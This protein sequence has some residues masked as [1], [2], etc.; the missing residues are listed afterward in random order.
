VRGLFRA[1]VLLAQEVSLGGIQ[2]RVER[3]PQLHVEM[4][5]SDKL[6]DYLFLSARSMRRLKEFLLAAGIVTEETAKTFRP[7]VTT[8]CKSLPQQMVGILTR[9]GVALDG[10]ATIEIASY[11]SAEQAVEQ[12]EA[13]QGEGQD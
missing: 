10:T 2:R 13:E 9:E 11:I 1:F 5:Q 12:F 7:D 3:Q 6:F 8:L 4:H